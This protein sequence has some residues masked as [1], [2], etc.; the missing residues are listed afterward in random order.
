MDGTRWIDILDKA[1][2]AIL[3]LFSSLI[4]SIISS[5]TE[6]RR[7]DREEKRTLKAEQ[8]EV[9]KTIIKQVES[10]RG[11]SEDLQFIM[12][13]LYD[14]N[15]GD[16]EMAKRYKR[17]RF[18]M[19]TAYD[20]LEQSIVVHFPDMV[21]EYINLKAIGYVYQ[22]NV[23]KYISEEQ[24]AKKDGIDIFREYEEPMITTCNNFIKIIADKYHKEMQ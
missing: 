12:I 15:Y 7:L 23:N 11:A 2:P 24:Y 18:N 1:V 17:A 8:K 14:G 20:L 21:N 10:L 13:S 9:V 3:V 6:K 22:K 19:K 5:R 4:P 16:T